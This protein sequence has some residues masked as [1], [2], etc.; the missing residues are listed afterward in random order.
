[1]S[2]TKY[3]RVAVF[4]GSCFVL[5]LGGCGSTEP[6][7]P[8]EQPD[9][10]QRADD[11]E[12]NPKDAGSK[13][14]SKPD[15]EPKDS[16]KDEPVQTGNCGSKTC[17]EP[18]TCKDSKCVCPEGYEDPKGDGSEC[19]DIDEC[20]DR[21]KCGADAR[22]VNKP[23]GFE[24]E[25]RAPAYKRQGDRCE[26]AD[27]YE[28]NDK[29]LCLANNGTKCTDNF[30][31]K[32]N[33]CEGGT[34][35]GQA[36]TDPAS[37]ES[38]DGAT[39]ED[40]KTCKYPKKKDGE[41]CDDGKACTRNGTC[42]AGACEPSTES[43]DCDDENPCTD[44]S[45]AE[46]EGCKNQNNAGTCD[47]GNK[48]T[49]EDKCSAG[50]CQGS[51]ID[52]SAAADVCNDGACD[53]ATGTCGKAPK[54][55]GGACDDG[56]DCTLTDA[57]DD[58]ACKGT[59]NACGPNATAC[60][61]GTPN[62]CTCAAGYEASDGLC[63]PENNECDTTSMCSPNATCF[64][65][66]NNSG[67]AKCTCKAGYQGDGMTC[68]QI[69]PCNPNPCGPGTCATDS[70]NAL[71]Y[72]CTCP[73]G[74]KTVGGTCACD[75]SGDFGIRLRLGTSWTDSSPIEDGSASSDAFIRLKQSYDAS[76][77][78]TME[79]MDCGGT[80]FDLCSVPIPPLLGAEAYAQY[81][82]IEIWGTPS[83]PK[84]T[85][86]VDLPKARPGDPY[87]T[88]NFVM[89]SGMSLTDP[90]G[91]FPATRK[92][93]SGSPAFD[94]SAT[95]G[96]VWL[97]QDDDGVVGVSVIVVGPG[98]ERP[99]GVPS[100]PPQT[101]GARS[102]VCPRGRPN[103]ERYEY[104][105]APALAGGLSPVRIKRMG[106]ASRVIM[107]YKGSVVSCDQ[108]SGDIVGPGA[109]NTIQADARIGSC[110]RTNGSGEGG[111]SDS[112][113]DFLD[114]QPQTQ[115]TTSAKFVIKRANANPTCKDIVNLNYD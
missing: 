73:A 87:E 64:D 86:T 70:A 74:Q 50:A 98:G 29:G 66:S 10:G 17:N 33:A 26:C 94:G 53:P 39:C 47:D 63:V 61:E 2:Y 62:D 14:A 48:C 9:A 21:G 55:K 97:D 13:D 45:C 95:N 51:A 101:F 91:P 5:P 83:M 109:G 113:I 114:T 25:C 49:S 52:C 99:D 110:V 37:C 82:P 54:A 68:T 7:P 18:E 32:S 112:A 57:C 11:Q 107:G 20:A 69:D 71:G 8:E 12:M 67:D 108:I 76:G 77:K 92:D 56:D 16:G 75:L 22:C 115:K 46:P 81:Y 4:I 111:C 1:M 106:T 58:G 105:Y 96:A 43:T 100:D 104:A 44:D 65:P 15:D 102:D 28:R 19:K 84:F 72:T 6:R 79:V 23:G 31:C 90:F 80:T 60:S 35:C 41:S 36:C 59:G 27:G 42:K 88:G 3:L 38:V 78:L 24:C 89:F 30:D 85:H 93:I 34:C 103:A 40:G